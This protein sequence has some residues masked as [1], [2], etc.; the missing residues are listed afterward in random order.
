MD[1]FADCIAKGRL[2]KIEPDPEKVAGEL[3][4]AVGELERSRARFR[5][6]IWDEATTLAYF[7]L[8]RASRAALLSKGFMDTNLYGLCTGLEQLLIAPGEL[9]SEVVVQLRE[10][11]SI[12]DS[13]YSGGRSSRSEAQQMLGWALPVVRRVLTLL[14]LPDLD[15][16]KV[17]PELPEPRVRPHG[18]RRPP[19]E[20]PSP[21]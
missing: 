18:D 6:G 21:R 19:E 15:P 20:D 13:V 4:S 3:R 10:G 12:K 2:K 9:P 5:G 1:R 16:S 11:K 14:S 17:D 7:A 8:Y